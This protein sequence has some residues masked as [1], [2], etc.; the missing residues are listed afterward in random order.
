MQKRYQVNTTSA[1]SNSSTIQDGTVSAGDYI[2]E[3]LND[4]FWECEKGDTNDQED[5][6]NHK[7]GFC[8]ICFINKA[9]EVCVPCGHLACCITCISQCD[10]KRCPVCN[11]S[12]TMYVTLR[13]PEI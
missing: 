9:T 10:C 2:V 5:S 6:N 12:F 7:S 1:S 13:E 4:S 8:I 11:V 3:I